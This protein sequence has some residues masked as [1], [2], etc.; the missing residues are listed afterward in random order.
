MYV[1]FAV[2]PERLPAAISSIRPLNLRGM[3]VTLPHKRAA[4]DL[5]NELTH[6]A[7]LADAVNTIARQDGHL[8]GDNTDGAGVPADLTNKL[9]LE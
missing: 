8:V 6:R 7:Q 5:V 1:P 2:P 9:R 3:N 4:A